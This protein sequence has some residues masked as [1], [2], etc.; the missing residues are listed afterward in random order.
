MS[1]RRG[2]PRSVFGTLALTLI[3]VV[4]LLT[5]PR[6]GTS[7]DGPWVA[8][9]VVAMVAG[10][11][12]SVPRGCVPVWQRV[13]G[14]LLVTGASWLLIGV[15]PDGIA[16]GAIYYVVIMSAL[17]LD[18]VPAGPDALASRRPTLVRVEPS[19]LGL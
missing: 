14:L 1:R 13:S 18:L 10:I 15:Q 16:F 8:L 17:R 7:G 3:V 5:E 12:I 4:T 6:P 2:Q 11:L 9:G 19:S